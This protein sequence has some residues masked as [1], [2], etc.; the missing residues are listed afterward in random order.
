[1]TQ[2]ENLDLD[3]WFGQAN[4]DYYIC[5]SVWDCIEKWIWLC[6]VFLQVSSALFWMEKEKI[7]L[8][9]LSRSADDFG[10]V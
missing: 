8:N 3:L 6:S 4:T 5:A 1:M 2:L 10:H 9:V 7:N